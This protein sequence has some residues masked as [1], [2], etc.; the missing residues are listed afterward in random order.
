VQDLSWTSTKYA[1]II[2]ETKSYII[3]SIIQILL[4]HCP[5]CRDILIPDQLVDDAGFTKG[6]IARLGIPT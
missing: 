5:K 1:A 2:V 4:R 3:K 6:K